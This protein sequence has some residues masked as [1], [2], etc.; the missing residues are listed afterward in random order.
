[1][2]TALL[3]D[4]QTREMGESL[5]SWNFA[6][7]P[8]LIAPT[9]FQATYINFA[10]LVFEDELGSELTTTLLR[11]WYFW[12]ERLQQMILSRS[13]SGLMIGARQSE[14]RQWTTSFAGQL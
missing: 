9:I 10:R 11:N 1:M 7:E 3:T 6:D 14:W 2:A 12:Q 4:E 8:H 5:S 13:S